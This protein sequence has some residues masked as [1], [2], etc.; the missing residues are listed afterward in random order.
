MRKVN[1]VSKSRFSASGVA[2]QLELFTNHVA[3]TSRIY[4]ARYQRM[5]DA[6]GE[7]HPVK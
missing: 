1:V 2:N 3:S 7:T 6:L 5:N 4:L